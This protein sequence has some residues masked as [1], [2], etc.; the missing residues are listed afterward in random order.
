[1]K[2]ELE[3]L[4]CDACGYT[5]RMDCPMGCPQCGASD[6]TADPQDHS[7]TRMSTR[8]QVVIPEA[9]RNTMGWGP[10]TV[11]TVKLQGKQ[12]ILEEA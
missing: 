5:I 3:R 6:W 10:G 7:T 11:I 9:E 1:M 12:L 4:R 2:K 8:G